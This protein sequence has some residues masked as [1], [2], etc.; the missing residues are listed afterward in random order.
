MTSLCRYTKW[1]APEEESTLD[2]DATVVDTG[3]VPEMD[4]AA[5]MG[6]AGFGGEAR[7]SEEKKK[8]RV[9]FFAPFDKMLANTVF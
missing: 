8:V 3:E 9:S 1:T 6:F 4:M 2:P 7:K 5:M